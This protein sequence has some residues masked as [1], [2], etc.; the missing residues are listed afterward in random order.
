MSERVGKPTALNPRL[1]EMPQIDDLFRIKLNTGLGSL[2]ARE[3]A[4]LDA[5]VAWC[6]PYAAYL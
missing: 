4:H 3:R 6:S 1:F 2:P 5:V